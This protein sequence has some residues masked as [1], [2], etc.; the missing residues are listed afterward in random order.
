MQ[1]QPTLTLE[2]LFSS[3]DFKVQ[4]FG[5]ARWLPDD[6]GYTIL[7]TAVS[8]PKIKELARYDIHSG[9]RTLLVTA[10]QLKP[11]GSDT[12]LL[13]DDYQ[14]SPDKTH[15]LIFSNSQRVWREKTRGDYWLLRLA[16]GQ[17]TQLGGDAPTAS[18]MFAKFSPDNHAVAYVR[19]QNIYVE[20][21]T[22]GPIIQLT[23][24]G[25]GDIINGTSDW[26]YEEEFRL[27][28]GF[29]WSPD[30]QH[31]A[32]WQFD[33]SG[34]EPFYLI[35]NTDSL[36]P[37]LL[38]LPYPKVGTTNAACRLGVVPASGG[39]TTWFDVPGDPRQHYIPKMEWAATHDEV[40]IQQLTRRQNENRVLLGRIADGTT[41]T[42]F[43]E[44][45]AAWVDMRGDDMQWLDDG[46][47]FTWVS[48]RDGWRRLYRCSRD[49]QTVTPL[50]PGDYDVIRVQQVV[51]AT[52]D[53][54]AGWVYFIASPQN[55]TQ[56]YLYRAALDGS[57]VVEQVT[58]PQLAGTHSYDI[59]PTGRWAFH[60]Y[61]TIDKPPV[62]TL[63]SL[64]DHQPLRVLTANEE[65]HAR[66]A[67]LHRLP[68]EFSVSP[69]LMGLSW[70]AGAS[71]RPT[72]TR[73]VATRCCFLC[74]G[75]R[76]GKRCWIIGAISVI[77]GM[78]CWHSMD[79]W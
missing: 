67:G 53:G 51:P 77:C 16:D 52:A 40:A 73:R 19:Q 12:P 62:L 72:L 27:R 47:A 64:P 15:L 75:N 61:A 18:L 1:V 37:R 25:G 74:M 59:A 44:T 9:E 22:G 21:L 14:W 54:A 10:A 48:D 79:L 28:D 76:P 56:R 11:Q 17:L 63:I 39:A 2:R 20:P 43:T 7:E 65:L 23:D 71:N 32:Y 33:T 58:P 68:T 49:G 55:A 50:T 60:T 29:R 4:P 30:S 38:P 31:I 36:Y 70:M 46:A 13:I 34:I 24:D 8:D 26:A 45:D 78:C 5:P 35:N 57:G 3:D 66:V 41:R 69:C 42:I 6:A